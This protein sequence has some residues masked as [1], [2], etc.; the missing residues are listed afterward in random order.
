[1]RR[2]LR[3]IAASPVYR[4]ETGEKIS[5]FA[6]SIAAIIPL[7]SGVRTTRAL[8]FSLVSRLLSQAGP[9]SQCAHRRNIVPTGA[10][11]RMSDA[12]DSFIAARG[13][14]PDRASAVPDRRHRGGQPAV[15]RRIGDL[16]RATKA[17]LS[18]VDSSAFGDGRAPA[19][20]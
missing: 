2:L 12:T 6:G 17:S 3:S 13:P 15:C 7:Q 20:K 8:L 19:T 9:F 1:M 16:A 4:S 11:G 10:D 18:A 14:V 5:S